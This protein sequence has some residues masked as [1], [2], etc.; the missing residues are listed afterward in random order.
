LHPGSDLTVG[1]S[2]RFLQ[3]KDQALC[4]PLIT[5]FDELSSGQ[6][7]DLAAL[8]GLT[9][10]KPPATSTIIACNPGD[11]PCLIDMDETDPAAYKRLIFLPARAGLAV[12]HGIQA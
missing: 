3:K 5:G 4:P 7:L 10:G 8:K 2:T 11:L 9:S 1:R 12:D 6:Q